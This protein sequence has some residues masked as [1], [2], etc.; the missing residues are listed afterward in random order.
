MLDDVFLAR[1]GDAMRAD[2]QAIRERRQRIAALAMAA[3]PS[4][5]GYERPTANGFT[6]DYML[7]LFHKGVSQAEIA[8]RCGVTPA[9]VHKRFAARRRKAGAA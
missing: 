2:A 4:L 3:R 7:D 9:T 6:T 5:V 8:R 1:F